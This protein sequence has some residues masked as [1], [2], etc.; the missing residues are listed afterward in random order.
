MTIRSYIAI[1]VANVS[2]AGLLLLGRNATT[3]PG[4]L[5][6]KIAPNLYPYLLEQIPKGVVFITGTNGKTTT[7]AMARHLLA[8]QFTIISNVGGSN[9]IRGHLTALVANYSIIQGFKDNTLALLE[10]DELFVAEA[11]NLGARPTAIAVLN[12]FR[13][14]L[15][16]FGEIDSITRKWEKALAKSPGTR[17]LINS[18]DPRLAALGKKYSE[19]TE[20]FGLDAP[21]LLLPKPSSMADTGDLSVE[22]SGYYVSHMGNYKGEPEKTTAL[23]SANWGEEH[24]KITLQVDT[25]TIQASLQTPGRY[26]LFNA[27]AALAI[28]K[29][30]MVDTYSV[31]NRLESFTP[32]FSR[33]EK[34]YIDGKPIWLVL[35]KN[36]VALSET[37]ATIQE[38][39]GGSTYNIILGSND[40]IADGKDVSWYFDADISSLSGNPPANCMCFGTRARD[41][42]LRL[43]YGLE[44]EVSLINLDEVAKAIGGLSGETFILTTYTA[45]LELR[46]T[47]TSQGHIKKWSTHA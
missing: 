9:L 26:N 25:E 21:A 7:T 39:V 12:L 35:V 1:A 30:L 5:A 43:S 6:E 3:L 37:L 36:P 38:M 11:I 34:V 41:M 28:A 19:R 23:T 27:V 2:R 18:N 24:W 8:E 4:L 47:L 46:E 45:T 15:D 20:Y 29:E 22:Y 14:Q 32:A 10:T 31:A 17:L 16:R 13:D 42:R 33:F 44:Q 40:N